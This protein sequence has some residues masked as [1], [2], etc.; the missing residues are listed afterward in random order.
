MSIP[1]NF[2]ISNADDTG[3]GIHEINRNPCNINAMD[4]SVTAG[5]ATI[6]SLSLFNNSRFIGI[7]VVV[8][9][10]VTSYI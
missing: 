3:G 8:G 2:V 1:M 9:T 4:D 6:L 7:V 10:L 5:D